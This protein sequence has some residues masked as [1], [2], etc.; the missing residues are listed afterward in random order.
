MSKSP[1]AFTNEEATV[2]AEYKKELD[3]LIESYTVEELEKMYYNQMT[4]QKSTEIFEEYDKMLIVDAITVKYGIDDRH[5]YFEEED[6]IIRRKA[7]GVLAIVESEK[8]IKNENGQYYF[9]RRTLQEAKKV[10]NDEVYANQTGCFYLYS[11]CSFR[12]YHNYSR[13]IVLNRNQN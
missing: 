12:E 11:V 2:N 3:Y 1:A 5:D 8:L 13:V 7:S 6:P 4:G 9:E 10:C